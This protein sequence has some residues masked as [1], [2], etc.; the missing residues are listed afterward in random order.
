MKYKFSKTNVFKNTILA[1][2]FTF[3]L[4]TLILVTL[5]DSLF[6]STWLEIFACFFIST[7]FAIICLCYSVIDYDKKSFDI[8]EENGSEILILYKNGKEYKRF[9]LSKVVGINIF[10]SHL[11]FN[12]RVIKITDGNDL[13][14]MTISESVYKKISSRLPYYFKSQKDGLVEIKSAYK[15]KTLVLKLCVLCFYCFV[16][17][18]ILTP[19]ICGTIKEIP[20]RYEALNFNY[21]KA[22]KV[23]VMASFIISGGVLISYS[24]YFFFKFFMYRNFKIRITDNFTLE[25]YRLSRQ[26][27]NYDLKTIVGIKRVRSLF[28]FLF[29]L[30]AL[31]V[32]WK[33]SGKEGIHNDCIPFCLTKSDCDKIEN[34]LLGSENSEK[35]KNSKKTYFYCI[36]PLILSL[37]LV[38]FASFLYGF[39]L[40]L[41]LFFPV[42]YFFGYY[43]NRYYSIGETKLLFSC[44]FLVRNK[45]IIKASEIQGITAT[46]R[47]FEKKLPYSTYELL[48]PGYNGCI[49]LGVYDDCVCE[50]IKKKLNK[51]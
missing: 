4:S 25:Y 31:Y 3:V 34:A 44:G 39:A 37:A 22:K 19:A 38:T 24:I 18:L 20:N 5:S 21:K 6:L 10:K 9:D 27:I 29:G 42:F 32:I 41:V 28:S 16:I 40:M 1:F 2:V 11:Y 26:K 15:L 17:F 49:P 14:K 8:V 23:I 47:F 13:F 35:K 50:I 51:L 33:N 46:K 30:E 48:L 12:T 45:Y 7:G 43:R 36:F